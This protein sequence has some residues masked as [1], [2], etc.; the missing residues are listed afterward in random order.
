M[1]IFTET[2]FEHAPDAEPLAQQQAAASEYWFPAIHLQE[3][4]HNQSKQNIPLK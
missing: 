4:Q 3:T 1:N 2:N